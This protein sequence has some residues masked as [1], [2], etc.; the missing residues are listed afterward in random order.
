MVSTLNF[1]RKLWDEI[2]NEFCTIVVGFFES[3]MIPRGA[4]M[5]WVTFIPKIEGAKEI[6]EFR[7]ISMVGSI[8]KVLPI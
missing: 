7:P 8:Y 3:G 6:H 1:I 2:G 4:N 5:T